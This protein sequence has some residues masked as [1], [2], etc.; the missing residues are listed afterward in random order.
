MPFSMQATCFRGIVTLQSDNDMVLEDIR[1]YQAFIKRLQMLD[2][3]EARRACCARRMEMLSE[4]ITATVSYVGKADLGGTERYILENEA[5]PST[6]LPST[7]VPLT[8][9]MSALNGYFFLNF[10]QYFKEMDY[11]SSFI[12][13]LRENNL[14]YDVLNVTEARYPMMELPM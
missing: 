5:L 3:V 8:V 9:E 13:Q 12:R 7:H 6:A 2:S 10:I 11:F 4:C 14:D 1:D